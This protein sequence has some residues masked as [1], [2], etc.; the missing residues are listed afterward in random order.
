MP[1]R[2]PYHHV[3]AERRGVVQIPRV[4]EAR[5]RVERARGKPGPRQLDERVMLAQGDRVRRWR[6]VADAAALLARAGARRVRD[7][8]GRHFHLGVGRKALRHRH[9]DRA[10]RPFEAVRRRTKALCHAVRVAHQEVG[11]VHEHAAVA[12]GGDGESPDDRLR[13]RVFDPLSFKRAATHRAVVVVGLHQH[14]FR[15]HALERHHFG[16]AQLR[17]VEADVIRAQARRHTGLIQELVIESRNFD[18]E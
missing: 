10:A 15:S 17:A 8:R 14:H 12:L 6:H 4:E 13:E 11:G 2:R 1:R 18:K 16:V 3:G 7:E 9:V 5:A